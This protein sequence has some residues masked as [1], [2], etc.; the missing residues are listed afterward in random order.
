MI[1]HGE[2]QKK[3]RWARYVAW[4]LR[5]IAGLVILIIV[6][7]QFW[8][9]PDKFRREIKQS[10]MKFCDGQVDIG[11]IEVNYFGPIYLGEVRFFDNTGRECLFADR[12]KLSFK[13]WPGLHPVL[14]RVDIDKLNL[15][16]S[17]P[18]G[19][20]TLPFSY[21]SKQPSGSKKRFDIREFS[22]EEAEITLVNT[23]GSETIYKNLQLLVLKDADTYDFNL[24]RDV[25]ESPELLSAKG[26]LNSKTLE[27]ELS[28]H[29]KH[30]VTKSEMA[31]ILTTLNASELSADG[32]LTANLTITGSLKP[33]S[34]LK[35]KGTID[36]DKWTVA[37]N[38][39]T[40]AG[41]LTTKAYAEDG[42]FDFDN[43]TASVFSGS[44][45]G[46]LYIENT[47]NKPTFF[48]GSVLSRGM[49]FVE[50]TSV[51]GGPGRKAT[52]G[53]VAFSYNFTAEGTDL[54]NL[55]GR[56]HIFL[57]DADITV[58]P[59]VPHLFRVI[60]LSRL[61][62]MEMADAGSTFTTAGPVVTVETAHIAN[63]FAAIRAEPGGTINLKTRQIDMYVVA[64]P[65]KQIDAVLG[66]IPIINIFVNLKDKLAR[67]RI[68][69]L[70]SDTP[71][72]LIT[73]EPIK[74]IQKATI[75]FLQDLIETGNWLT[76]PIRKGLG[77]KD[78]NHPN[79]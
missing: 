73:K 18:A 79:N 20:L 23:Q 33:L 22:I 6:V 44:A 64:L 69:G 55:T 34:A 78:G 3:G 26:T 63:L 50:L 28:L 5:I 15:Q 4:V 14:T 58:I 61:N 54:Q 9:V 35:P 48:G 45:L 7:G 74:D 24:F 40:I 36:L 65:I 67:F 27:I 59:V 31:L 8:F 2:I 46:S 25:P 12:V 47:S 51:I 72:K 37:K 17:A 32:N 43:I 62:P 21:P 76:Q 53:V 75:A 11:N 42:R 56:G 70:W 71:A 57:D 77:V 16:I 13:K 19:R 66:R 60:A 41:N 1:F 52:K 49:D 39:K 38:G 30:I 10:L 29:I 68:R